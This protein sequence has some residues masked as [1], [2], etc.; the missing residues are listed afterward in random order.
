M[1]TTLFNFNPLSICGINTQQCNA[2][3]KIG[4]VCVNDV[5]ERAI[6]NANGFKGISKETIIKL[7]KIIKR[8]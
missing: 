8:K 1:Q 2:L 7:R 3:K 4:I 6:D 5:S